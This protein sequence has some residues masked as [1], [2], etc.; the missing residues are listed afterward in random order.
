MGRVGSEVGVRGHLDPDWLPVTH[1]RTS[2]MP[3]ELLLP[4]AE[5]A[6][7]N[8][9]FARALPLQENHVLVMTPQILL[10]VLNAGAAHFHQIALLVRSG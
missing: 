10:N 7:H 8:V 5:G 9:G 1:V 6:R 2:H 4:D 3:A